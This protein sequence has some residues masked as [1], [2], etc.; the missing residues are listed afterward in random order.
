MFAGTKGDAA[1]PPANDV[2]D[3]NNSRFF[4]HG[5]LEYEEPVPMNAYEDP[6]AAHVYAQAGSGAAPRTYLTPHVRSRSSD[7]LDVVGGEDDAHQYSYAAREQ[8]AVT[9]DN[10]G[11]ELPGYAAASPDLSEQVYDVAGSTQHTASHY[12]VAS[13]PPLQEMTNPAFYDMAGC[14]DTAVYDR[15]AAPATADYDIG[16]SQADDATIYDVAT[17]TI[18]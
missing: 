18:A 2:A 6:S 11:A 8:E 9:Y 14:G 10:V 13:Q 12:D 4:V 1:L 5:P 15:A 3:D 17:N 7:Y 16:A